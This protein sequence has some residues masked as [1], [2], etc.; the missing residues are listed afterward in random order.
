[1]GTPLLC[2]YLHA[3]A[4]VLRQRAQLG[5]MSWPRTACLPC[6]RSRLC[7]S[8]EEHNVGAPLN[9]IASQ[10]GWAPHCACISRTPRRPRGD[11]LHTRP[12]RAHR[13]TA[14]RAPN[15]ASPPRHLEVPRHQGIIR[16]LS[17]E[18]KNIK[19]RGGEVGGERGKSGRKTG[20]KR[21]RVRG[22][23]NRK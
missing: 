5:S 8:G 22:K 19:L 11:R 16:R 17:R 1:M 12:P 18:D 3:S 14:G 9:E 4:T 20:R 23:G 7:R 10:Q 13:A 21:G 15:P 2:R 6:S